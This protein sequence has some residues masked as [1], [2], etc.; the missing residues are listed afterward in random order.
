[1]GRSSG[2]RPNFRVRAR[3]SRVTARRSIPNRA[4]ER[5]GLGAPAG[6]GLPNWS[7]LSV[8]G[9]GVENQVGA[10]HGRVDE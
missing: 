4:V 6:Q 7:E 2:L 9:N 8:V 10:S 1:M 3:S 5:G